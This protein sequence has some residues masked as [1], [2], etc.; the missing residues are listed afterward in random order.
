MGRGGRV[1]KEVKKGKLESLQ[2]LQ[3]LRKKILLIFLRRLVVFR[4]DVGQKLEEKVEFKRDFGKIEEIWYIEML[5][6]GFRGQKEVE[7]VGR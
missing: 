7:D 6:V 3:Q 5:I 4:R 2:I 1:T